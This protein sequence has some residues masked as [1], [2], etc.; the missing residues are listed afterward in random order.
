MY[1]WVWDW[2]WFAST[3]IDLILDF[4]RSFES[5]LIFKKSFVRCLRGCWGFSF[6]F[7]I[8]SLNWAFDLVLSG[9]W[10]WFSWFY[11]QES[12]PEFWFLS[13]FFKIEFSYLAIWSCFSSYS[14]FLLSSSRIIFCSS[15]YPEL[16]IY[17]S[18]FFVLWVAFGLEIF[19]FY[20][21]LSNYYN[22]NTR[23]FILSK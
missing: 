3:E 21:E 2:T 9:F 7:C 6:L 13:C 18:W 19:R 10:T 1:F 23:R 4:Y 5:W 12:L 15:S 22:S 20:T 17:F 14:F 8:I 11:Y 16:L